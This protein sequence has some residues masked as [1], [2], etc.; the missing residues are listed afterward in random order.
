MGDRGYNN[1]VAVTVGK[2]IYPDGS[3]CDALFIGTGGGTMTVED[4]SG[5][6]TEFA[7]GTNV[8]FILPV[9]AKQVT[10]VSTVDD[11]VALRKI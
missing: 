5:N 10:A 7:I 8:P 3:L 1:Y 9:R 11:I 6:T 2:D 4:Q